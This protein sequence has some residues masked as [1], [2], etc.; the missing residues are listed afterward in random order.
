M[1]DQRA[2][3]ISSV[4]GGKNSKDTSG[5]PSPTFRRGIVDRG[6]RMTP[7][8]IA[9]GPPD[10]RR[11]LPDIVA[12]PLTAR[13]PPAWRSTTIPRRPHCPDRSPDDA[14]IQ[15]ERGRLAIR[16]N[17]VIILQRSFESARAGRGWN[18]K[19]PMP[20]TNLGGS[21]GAGRPAFGTRRSS[22]PL[23][24]ETPERRQIWHPDSRLA[25]FPGPEGEFHCPDVALSQTASPGLSSP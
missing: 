12:D 15:P 20:R 4:P 2:V 1:V 21:P 11:L 14:N 17:N 13:L 10:R 24:C 16:D 19:S 25:S 5:P 7:S 6:G 3:S 23:G 18:W 8:G 22:E 9:R